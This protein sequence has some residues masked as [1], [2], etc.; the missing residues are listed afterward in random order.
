M[1]TS[2]GKKSA[3]KKLLNVRRSLSALAKPQPAK[4][5]VAAVANVAL[6][7]LYSQ[8]GHHVYTNELKGRRAECGRQIVSTASRQVAERYRREV[9]DKSLRQMVQF[10]IFFLE[11]EIAST[12]WRQSTQRHFQIPAPTRGH[13]LPT[14]ENSC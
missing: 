4:T 11:G 6:T 12:S 7:A 9:N 1:T 10:A 5:Q 2:L 14:A 8:L 3:S 13:S